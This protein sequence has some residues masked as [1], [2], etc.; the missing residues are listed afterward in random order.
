MIAITDNEFASVAE[1]VGAPAEWK[2]RGAPMS[3]GMVAIV[4]DDVVVR[5]AMKSLMRSLGH[6]ASTFGSAEEFSTQSVQQN[7]VPHHRS[8]YAGIER[9]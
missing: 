4:D 7:I 5:G 1:S 3:Q 2:A 9:P 8:A 6:D